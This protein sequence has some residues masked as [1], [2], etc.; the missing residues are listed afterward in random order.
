MLGFGAVAVAGGSQSEF[1]QGFDQAA[2]SHGMSSAGKAGLLAPCL[3]CVRAGATAMATS[4]LVEADAGKA[5][6]ELP[7]V[8]SCLLPP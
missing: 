3:C 1:V 8:T 5:R 2:H 6:E 4:C 7:G